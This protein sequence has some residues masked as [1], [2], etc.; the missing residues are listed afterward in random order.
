[1]MTV[2]F[3]LIERSRKLI[4]GNYSWRRRQRE[5]RHR[6]GHCVLEQSD[7]GGGR[8][9]GDGQNSTTVTCSELVTCPVR[10]GPL[11]GNNP[12]M[13]AITLVLLALVSVAG[14]IGAGL[15]VVLGFEEA[16]EGLLL[17]STVGLLALPVVLFWDL[18]LRRASVRRRVVLRALLGRRAPRALSVCLR[19]AARQP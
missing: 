1:M 12:R 9:H 6:Q 17:L 18:L 3:R 5:A 11:R 13:R 8:P 2:S 10:S 19:L 14:M 15:A 4:K 7:S 16:P